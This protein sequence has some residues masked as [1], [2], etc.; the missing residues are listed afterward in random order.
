MSKWN[1]YQLYYTTGFCPTGMQAKQGCEWKFLDDNFRPAKNIFF[2]ARNEKEA[3][4]KANKF[5][6]DGQMG[7]G[8]IIVKQINTV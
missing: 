8:R 2:K 1:T 5:W 7:G 3:M 4:K 6:R